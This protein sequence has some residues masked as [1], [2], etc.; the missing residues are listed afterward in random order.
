MRNAKNK[1]TFLV[2]EEVLETID[3][4]K[5]THKEN[6]IEEESILA[7]ANKGFNFNKFKKEQAEALKKLPLN[8]NILDQ[9]NNVFDF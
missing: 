6:L 9:V 1:R 8:Y 3:Y 2:N 7:A 4:N 5:P